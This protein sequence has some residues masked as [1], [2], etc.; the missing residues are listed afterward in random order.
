M[1][2]FS[3]ECEFNVFLKEHGLALDPTSRVVC[4]AVDYYDVVDQHG[5]FVSRV[6]FVCIDNSSG[7]LSHIEF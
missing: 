4:N 6:A 2:R 7:I 5:D 1:K 3:S